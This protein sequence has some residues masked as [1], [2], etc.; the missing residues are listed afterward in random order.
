MRGHIAIKN[1]RY[2]P[3][4]SIKDPATGKW[5]RKWLSGHKTK[6]DAEKATTEAVAQTNNGWLNLPS[7]ETVGELCH[8]YL[9]NTAP[10][11]IRPI[12]LQS[13]RQILETHLISK[14]GAKPVAAFTPDDLNRVMASMIKNGRSVTT[15]R[16][17]HR[18]VHRVLDDAVKKGKLTRNVADLADPP[19]A[20]TYEANTWNEAELDLFLTAVASSEYSGYFALLATT[21]LTGGRRGEALGIRWG[22]IDWD[23]D[24]PKLHIRLTVYKLENGEWQYMPPKTRRSNRVIDI[25]ISLMLLLRRLKEQQEAHAEWIG[26]Q[27]TEDDFAFMRADGTLP[28]PRYVSKVFRHIVEQ[29]GLPRI[30]L[31]DLRHTFATL[32]RKHGRSI[33]EISQ[34]LGHASEAVTATVYNHWKGNSRAVADTMDQILENAG[35]NENKKAFVRNSLEEGEGIECRPYR[36]RTCDTLI[37]SHGIQDADLLHCFEAKLLQ[38]HP[39]FIDQSGYHHSST[40]PA[41]YLSRLYHSCPTSN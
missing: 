33:E 9:T 4:I 1:G 11:R 8:D 23:K 34:A 31:H 21:A 28:D 14:I 32:L 7:R 39:D 38:N 12:T 35:E 15:A 10:L 2:Y 16:Y 25:P 18:V 24:A 36:S 3:V 37:K 40:P 27:F 41:D 17:L 13:Y 19:Q 20:K 22:D 5:K 30:R 26:R 6:R 29:A